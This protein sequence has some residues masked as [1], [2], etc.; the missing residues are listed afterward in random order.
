MICWKSATIATKA[1]IPAL[2]FAVGVFQQQAGY[3]QEPTQ[4]PPAQSTQSEAQPTDPAPESPEQIQ[5]LVAPIALY[6]DALV[7]QV[8]SGA[9]FPDQISLARNWMLQHKDLSSQELMKEVD[10]QSWDPKSL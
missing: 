7:A 8:F 3:A 1:L 10:Q 6:P 5:A 4:T 2:C 9:T